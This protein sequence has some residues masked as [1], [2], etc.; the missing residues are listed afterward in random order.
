M[1]FIGQS[2]LVISC[3][4]DGLVRMH[5]SDNAQNL[6]NFAGATDFMYSAD[7]TPDGRVVAAGGFDGVLRIWNGENAQVMHV[8]SPP[9]EPENS[10]AAGTLGVAK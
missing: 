9:Q 8:I 1:R 10:V 3:S 5:N 6:R 2:S 7:A 4:G